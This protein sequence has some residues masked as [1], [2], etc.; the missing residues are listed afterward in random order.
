MK[1]SNIYV[2]DAIC[3]LLLIEAI[4]RDK[5]ISVDKFASLYN[6]L[7]SQMFKIKVA[8]RSIF[9]TTKEESRLEHPLPLQ[10]FID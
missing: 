6:D 10:H 3:N 9:K 7:P 8:D 4:L 2:G 1:I 5:G